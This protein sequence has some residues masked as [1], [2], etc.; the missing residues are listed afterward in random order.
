VRYFQRTEV[1]AK[2][3][4]PSVA[5][6]YQGQPTSASRAFKATL[7]WA[8]FACNHERRMVVPRFVSWNSMLNWLRAVDA[9]EERLTWA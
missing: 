6:I 8:S 2:V 7:R 3:G 4:L 9:L 5:F 1:M